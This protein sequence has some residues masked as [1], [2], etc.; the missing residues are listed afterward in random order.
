MKPGPRVLVTV[1]LSEYAEALAGMP[2][3]GPVGSGKLRG[4]LAG[5]EGAPKVPAGPRV[6]TIRQGVTPMKGR[7]LVTSP[8]VVSLPVFLLEDPWEGTVQF[9]TVA[10]IC[11]SARAAASEATTTARKIIVD[12]NRRVQGVL[13]TI[14][15]RSS[16]RPSLSMTSFCRPRFL[17]LPNSR[18]PVPQAPF[19]RNHP[20]GRCHFP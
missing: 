2:A 12:R 20:V 10:P 15:L 3:H 1:M 19:E 11:P 14:L 4:V 17:N 6:S 5:R 13:I 8:M 16:F 7:G 18:K 9:A